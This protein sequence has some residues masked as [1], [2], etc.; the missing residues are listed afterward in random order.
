MCLPKGHGRTVTTR[1]PALVNNQ[2]ITMDKF[3]KRS[4][5]QS[6]NQV[7]PAPVQSFRFSH[8]TQHI[9]DR[10]ATKYGCASLAEFYR[11]AVEDMMEISEQLH[12]DP[13]G[14]LQMPPFMR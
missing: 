3:N 1:P 11:A 2:I 7:G 4:R 12:K 5:P 13:H 14:A 10:M 6:A 8:E 9:A